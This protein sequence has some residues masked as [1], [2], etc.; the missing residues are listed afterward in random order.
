VP[1][2]EQALAQSDLE[3][4]RIEHELGDDWEEGFGIWHDAFELNDAGVFSVSITDAINLIF[5]TR[6]TGTKRKPID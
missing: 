3:F 2:S 5:N 1:F 4:V 6:D